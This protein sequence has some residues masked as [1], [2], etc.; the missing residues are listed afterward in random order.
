MSVLDFGQPWTSIANISGTDQ[1]TGKW[2][3][4]LSTTI[5][6]PRAINPFGKLWTTKTDLDL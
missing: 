5:F 6:F 1:A 3:T 2:K 4:A